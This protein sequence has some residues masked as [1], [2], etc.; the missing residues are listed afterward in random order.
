MNVKLNDDYKKFA[1]ISVKKSPVWIF[2]DEAKI[3]I[4]VSEFR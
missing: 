3:N 4:R 2:S 1:I